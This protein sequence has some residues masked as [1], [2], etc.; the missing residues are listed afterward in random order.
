MRA[1]F[2]VTLIALLAL[3]LTFVGVEARSAHAS[4]V[5]TEAVLA[6]PSEGAASARDRVRAQLAREDV[7]RE[8]RARGVD[9]EQ[10][11]ARVD[12]LSDAEL[13]AIAGRLDELPA[14]GSAVGAIVTALLIVFIIL[15]ITDIAGVT[16][17]FPFVRKPQNRRP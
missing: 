16:D 6:G 2:R 14:G 4:L 3:G 13:A 5:S 17:V 15:L 7:G 1:C 11:R 10:V 12:A 8:L 9:L